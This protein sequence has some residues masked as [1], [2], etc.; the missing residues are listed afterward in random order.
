[1]SCVQYSFLHLTPPK[2]H[3]QI[4]ATL[5]STSITL[6]LKTHPAVEILR[7]SHFK[8]F[9]CL[10][11]KCLPQA[12]TTC[13]NDRHASYFAQAPCFFAPQC[14]SSSVYY[15]RWEHLSTSRSMLGPH[16]QFSPHSLSM[17]LCNAH[18]SDTW[19][20]STGAMIFISVTATYT[21]PKNKSLIQSFALMHSGMT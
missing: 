16:L 20:L 4:P 11:L 21:H 7:L 12:Q 1:M 10:L 3:C 15:S 9:G 13:S 5:S 18:F 6:P 14:W 17:W 8:P 2:I 19:F